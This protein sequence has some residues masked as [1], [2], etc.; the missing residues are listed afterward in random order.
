MGIKVTN[1][2]LIGAQPFVHALGKLNFEGMSP[3]EK[4]TAKYW[5]STT[6][7][8]K[9]N[10]ALGRYEMAHQSL[11]EEEGNAEY[12]EDG[13]AIK[14][15]AKGAESHRAL[16]DVVAEVEAEPLRLPYIVYAQ[17]TL[18]VVYMRN[19]GTVREVN[20]TVIGVLNALEKFVEVLAPGE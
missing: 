12:D 3:H 7:L 16:L 14:Y 17:D 6:F 19:D 15:T 5:Y 10:E 9:F 11:V 8:K 18:P 20:E 2:E 4:A 1:A 13:K